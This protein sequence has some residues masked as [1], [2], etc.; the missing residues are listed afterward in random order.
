LIGFNFVY[1]SR[2]LNSGMNLPRRAI[3]EVVGEKKHFHLRL[4]G[5][6]VAPASETGSLVE[7]RIRVSGVTEYLAGIAR[8]TPA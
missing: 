2:H 7:P 8:I 6:G 1:N 5:S 4:Q 3:A